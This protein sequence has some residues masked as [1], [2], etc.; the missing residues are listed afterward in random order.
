MN[1]LLQINAFYDR[2]ELNPLNSSEIALWHAL[3][4]I[5]NKAAWSNTF[6]VA[7]SVLCRRSGIKDTSKSSNFYKAR[8]ALTQQGFITWESRKGNQSAK[9]SITKLYG[10]LSTYSVDNSVDSSVGNS[11]DSGVDNSVAL[12]KHK[13]KQ[14]KTSRRNRKK[15]VYDQANDFMKLAVYLQKQI[16]LNNPDFKQPNL[17]TWA[18][19]MRKLVELD[20]RDKHQVALV[21]KWCQHDSFWSTNILSARKLRDQYDQLYLKMQADQ[22]STP[23]QRVSKKQDEHKKWLRD[24]DKFVLYKYSETGNDLD[25]AMPII[26]AEYPQVTKAEAERILHPE[27]YLAAGG[28]D[29]GH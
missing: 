25:E 19:D 6:T 3:M 10:N 4:S 18:D 11:V 29:D 26:Q 7:S 2:L 24:R 9:Y 12:N 16:M 20:H 23:E 13:Q 17:Q 22:G 1:Y 8:N 28:V 21:I 14:K 27:L 15:P 5:N